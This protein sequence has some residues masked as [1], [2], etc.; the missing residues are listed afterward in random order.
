MRQA[1]LE[2]TN[3]TG[4]AECVILSIPLKELWTLDCILMSMLSCAT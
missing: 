1:K 4:D 3:K 2:L